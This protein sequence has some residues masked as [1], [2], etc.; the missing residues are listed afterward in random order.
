MAVSAVTARATTSATRQLRGGAMVIL[1][2]GGWRR[3]QSLAVPGAT[4]R[5]RSARA[6]R[7]GSK[8]SNEPVAPVAA[9]YR[10]RVAKYRESAQEQA[11][12]RL[13]R[14]DDD[15]E[16]QARVLTKHADRQS[17]AASLVRQDFNAFSFAWLPSP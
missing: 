17:F 6:R 3:Q 15:A 14:F 10:E 8:H 4:T 5:D 9:K 13:Q 7:T 11:A 2:A 1:P 12:R 16:F